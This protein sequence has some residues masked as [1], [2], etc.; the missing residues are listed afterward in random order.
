M[1]RNVDIAE[2]LERLAAL[3]ELDGADPYRVNAYRQAAESVRHATVSVAELARQG[4]A[5]ELDRVGPTI[6]RKIR[7]F[8]E[9]GTTPALER[10]QAKYP[11]GLLEVMRVPGLGAKR[12]R[13]LWERLGVGSLEDLERALETGQLSELPGFGE[14]TVARLR[15]AVERLRER[16]LDERPLLLI[17]HAE[18]AARRIAEALAATAGVQTSHAVGGLRRGVEATGD[19]DLLAVAPSSASELAGL[20]ARSGAV[21]EARPGDPRL[22]GV[23]SDDVG[24]ALVVTHDG[25][26]VDLWSV[27][28]AAHYAAL[29]WLTGSRAHNERLRQIAQEKGVELGPAG[30]RRGGK[31]LQVASEDDVYELLGM[32]WV[33]PELREDRGEVEAAQVGSLPDLITV[34]QLRGDLHC[35]TT[36]SDGRADARTMALAARERGYEYLAITDHSASHG[37][38]NAVSP[39]ELEQQI[40]RIAALNA[41]L[42]GIRLLAGSEI[43]LRPDGSL[44]YPE[45]LV[46]RLDWV[47]ASVH[48]SFALSEREMTARIAAAMENPLVDAIG[49]PTGRL[50]GRR[51]PYAV[52]VERLIEVAAATGTMLE[53]NSNPDRRDLSE[54]WARLAAE[55]GVMLVINSDAH[56]VEGLDV[57]RYGVATA[58]RAWLAPRSIA[59]TLSW[60]QLAR[61]RKR[62][63]A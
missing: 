22:T 28:P 59:N 24:R 30:V 60:D 32:A 58:R 31:P 44:D 40:E 51:D 4:R 7:D 36:L 8:V 63:R 35:H 41:E 55:A 27:Q 50:I 53:I 1:L 25:I 14:R 19:V 37:F 21:A 43:S 46:A 45:E 10:L 13:L 26:E 3:Y 6:A 38:G 49:H 33:P 29:Q 9:T 48:T 57:V 18:D 56:S 2:M 17:S 15:A 42:E 39:A 20:L 23:R 62:V 52:D 11:R 5:T 34:E 47:I 61:R 54:V 12:A 16:P